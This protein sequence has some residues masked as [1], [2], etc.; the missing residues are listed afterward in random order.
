MIDR[1]SFLAGTAGAVLFAP[2]IAAAQGTKLKLSH[3][4]PPMHQMHGWL[5]GWTDGLREKSGGEIDVEIFPASQMGPAG[6][7]FDLVRTGVADIGFFF[8]ALTPGRFPLSDVHLMS[9]AYARPDTL[10]PILAGQ[11]SEIATGLFGAYASDYEGTRPLLGVVTPG[12]GFFMKDRLVRKVSDVSG[13]RL[14][15]RGR[16]WPPTSRR[17]VDRTPPSR[18]R[19][20]RTRSPRARSM[21]RCSLSRRREPSSSEPR[22]RRSRCCRRAPACSC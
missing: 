7:Q 18:R 8:P 17:G 12:G 3:Y 16:Y 15:P 11:A 9:F 13:L 21:A 4:L 2:H 14:G 6:R 10:R 5:T 19:K 22:S 1:R 20:S